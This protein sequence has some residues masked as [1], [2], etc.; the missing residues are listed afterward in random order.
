MVRIPD[1]EELHLGVFH[2]GDRSDRPRRTRTATGLCRS[3]GRR[4]AGSAD[5][6]R[7]ATHAFTFP[8]PTIVPD[9]TVERPHQPHD[10]GPGS[11]SRAARARADERHSGTEHTFSINVN[12][13]AGGCQAFSVIVGRQ[14]TGLQVCFRVP[15]GL[16]GGTRTWGLTGPFLSPRFLQ[17]APE[18]PGAKTFYGRRCFLRTVHP[19]CAARGRAWP[20]SR[21]TIPPGRDSWRPPRGALLAVVWGAWL[22]CMVESAVEGGAASRIGAALVVA[23]LLAL[24]GAALA[25]AGSARHGIREAAGRA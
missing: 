7:R 25:F 10:V 21:W 20:L 9:G 18:S 24:A 11:A 13:G 6:V 22:G 5:R 15:A 19:A 14:A 16:R 1:T 23:P 8:W 4:G 2:P 17:A 3:K 12:D